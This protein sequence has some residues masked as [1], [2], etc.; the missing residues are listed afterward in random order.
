M[1]HWTDSV[2]VRTLSCL[3][4]SPFWR[5]RRLCVCVCVF[6]FLWAVL[7]DNKSVWLNDWYRYC[8]VYVLICIRLTTIDD[9]E[10]RYVIFWL[11]M[12]LNTNQLPSFFSV[13]GARFLSQ[14]CTRMLVP[15]GFFWASYGTGWLMSRICFLCFEFQKDRTKNAGAVGGRNFPSAIDKAHRLYNSLLLP[16]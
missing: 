7:R 12:L 11:A 15:L 14:E 9:G 13:A 3:R 8:T 16:H 2:F 1:R 4:V 6:N 10:R 5:V